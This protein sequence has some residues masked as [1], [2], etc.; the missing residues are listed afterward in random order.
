MFSYNMW[1]IK[2]HVETGRPEFLSMEA[3][4]AVGVPIV[5]KSCYN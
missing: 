5:V 1:K 3:V 2:L 4:L